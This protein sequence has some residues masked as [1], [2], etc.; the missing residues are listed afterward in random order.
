MCRKMYANFIIY[1]QNCKELAAR[2]PTLDILLNYNQAIYPVSLAGHRK[3][4]SINL[5]LHRAAASFFS[6]KYSFTVLGGSSGYSPSQFAQIQDASGGK[7]CL[8]RWPVG[9]SETRLRF[10]HDALL[11]SYS[12]GFT[13]V[14]ALRRTL[15]GNSYIRREAHLYEVQ[16][17]MQGMPLGQRRPFGASMPNAVAHVEW[18]R[19]RDLVKALAAFHSSTAEFTVPGDAVIPIAH[20]FVRLKQNFETF[21]E[22][23][24]RNEV[25][26]NHEVI[27]QWLDRLPYLLSLADTLIAAHPQAAQSAATLCHGDLWPQHVFFNR[28]RFSG[29]TDFE[30]LCF[31]SSIVDLAQVILHFTEWSACACVV[32]MYQNT[33]LLSREE[34]AL[35]PAAAALD[36]VSEGCWAIEALRLNRSDHL[37]QQSHRKNLQMLLPSVELILQQSGVI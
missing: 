21:H 32:E 36:L 12:N 13:G 7:W 26:T 31:T 30:S 29:F 37:P 23:I 33:R 9:M 18:K 27:R 2:S 15:D 8:R 22:Q 28:G 16:A 17:W 10:I 34:I 3:M 11:Y 5:D 24:R 20:Q 6:G 1:I 14:P 25:R 19:L 4:E 35:L